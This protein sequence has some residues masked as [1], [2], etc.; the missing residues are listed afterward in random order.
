M[1]SLQTFN[2]DQRRQQNPNPAQKSV[3]GLVAEYELLDKKTR[4]ETAEY[5]QNAKTIIKNA[6]EEV[7]T[8]TEQAFVGSEDDKEE[9]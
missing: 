4:L 3:I 7:R 8:V 9:L 6:N 1:P 2:T 5:L